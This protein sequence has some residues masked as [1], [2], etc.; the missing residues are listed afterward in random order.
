MAAKKRRKKAARRVGKKKT[1]RT[2]KK[3]GPLSKMGWPIVN[4][5]PKTGRVLPPRTAMNPITGKLYPDTNAGYKRAATDFN[6]HRD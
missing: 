4:F 1:R 5:H 3:G 6:Q 2:S